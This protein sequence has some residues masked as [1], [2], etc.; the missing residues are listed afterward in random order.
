MISNNKISN[1]VTSQVPFYVRND[2]EN[3]V[4]FME[5]YY[6][7]LEQQNGVLNISRSLL[8]QS[9]IDQTDLFANNFYNNFI[10]LIPEKTLVDK[11]LILKNIKD[12]YRSRGSEKSIRFLMRVL[13]NEEVEFYYPQKDVLKVSDGKWFVEKSIKISDVQINGQANTDINA[14]LNFVS[15]QIKGNTSNAT[16]LVEKISTYY[17]G[18]SLVR[19]LKIS[20]QYKD[21][22]SGEKIVAT[23]FDQ[24]EEKTISADLFSG[25][26]NT[27]RITNAGSGYKVGDVIK[28]ESNT[29]NGAIVEIAAV[30]TGGLF[31]FAVLEGG[32][33]YR[34]G[35][36][37]NLTG[38][39]GSGAA[40]NISTVKDDNFFHPN[41]YNIVSS[42]IQLEAGTAISNTRY[43]NMNTT[44]IVNA[45]TPMGDAF[46]YFK[47]DKTGP[48][49][50]VL[51]YNLG[52]GYTTSPK[53]T[54]IANNNV[55]RLGILGKMKI[56]NGGAGYYIGD[57]IEFRNTVG[58]YG[59][60]ANAVVRNVDTTASNTITEVQFVNVLG[61]ITGGSG[62]DQS[63]LPLATVNSVNTLAYGA[64]IMVTAILGAGDIYSPAGT[65]DGAI[66]D[67]AIRSRGTGY[68]SPPTLNLKSIGDGTA[69]AV[70]TIITGAF[71]YPGRY[72]NDDGH[73]SSYN[74]IEDR[75]YYQKFSYVVKLKQ[76]IEKYR[77]VLKNLIHPAGMKLFGE[78]MNIDNGQNLQ[79]NFR[80]VTQ[81]IIATRTQT[82]SHNI[83]NV[84]IAYAS[85]GLSQGN[86]VY[87]DWLTGNLAIATAN[88]KGP[89]K[90]A[91]NVS[92]GLFRINT[93][94]YIANTQLAN[95]TGS[96]NVGRIIY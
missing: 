90:V 73:I 62:Y 23:F 54:A 9:D 96:V 52:S 67:L 8:D 14:A 64:N 6:E 16:A 4:A 78:Y 43:A 20:N 68:T 36:V 44:H 17:D 1:L 11:N 80:G 51:L 46:S 57:V 22:E 21:F 18:N 19:E 59:S 72:L 28:V 2:H 58:G 86:T 3:F 74:F 10:P 84:T 53:A 7:F 91:T 15:R 75:D 34:A 39:G 5:A 69:Q 24:G 33:G 38:G 37:L 41:T 27:L 81:N 88:I 71:T 49:E 56:V 12:F 66:L 87:L 26:L 40:A 25:S 77:K 65:T 48:I 83:G 42:I 31:G 50:T 76:S 92:A 61:H 95:T 94:A 89:Y 93:N 79:V 45:T 32:A 70:A 29:G 82:Y 13:F 63:S 60:G 47:Y 35:D 55:V 85:H 30:S